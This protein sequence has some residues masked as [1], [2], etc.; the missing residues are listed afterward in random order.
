CVHAAL[1][2]G[3]TVALDP[4]WLPPGSA[5]GARR[6]VLAIAQ[7]PERLHPITLDNGSYR[8]TQGRTLLKTSLAS[9]PLVQGLDCG[10][11]GGHAGAQG[12]LGCLRLPHRTPHQAA[13]RPALALARPFQ[14]HWPLVVIALGHLLGLA[15]W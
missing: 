11:R 9:P 5:H 15:V 12:L 14:A 1:D 4:R 10:H 8:R 3:M 6:G 13:L 2:G 7:P